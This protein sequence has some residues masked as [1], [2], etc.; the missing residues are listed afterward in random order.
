MTVDV[1]PRTRRRLWVVRGY[2]FAAYG[3]GNSSCLV[4]RCIVTYSMTVLPWSSLSRA[5]SPGAQI[6][7]FGRY[8]NFQRSG[9]RFPG[10]SR[11]GTSKVTNSALAA[12]SYGQWRAFEARNSGFSSR[13][14]PIIGVRRVIMQCRAHDDDRAAPAVTLGLKSRGHRPFSPRPPNKVFFQGLGCRWTRELL[15]R[16]PCAIGIQPVHTRVD[17][18]GLPPTAIR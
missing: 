16:N 15:A 14:L 1:G 17:S 8:T 10:K 3:T 6:F 2:L 5:A 11:S 18:C 7:L 4:L 13:P 12:G 9:E